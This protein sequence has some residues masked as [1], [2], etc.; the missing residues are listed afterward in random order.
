MK[1][2]FIPQIV[3]AGMLAATLAVAPLSLPAQAQTNN[4]TGTPGT[5]NTA[6]TQEV[7]NTDDGFDWGWLGLI[8]LAG[9]AGL[10]GRKREEPVAYRD[11]ADVSGRSGSIR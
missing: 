6:T 11:P 1:P 3:G 7:D 5:D 8:G 9:L 10:A 4:T 2:S